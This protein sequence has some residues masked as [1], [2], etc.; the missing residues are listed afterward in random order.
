MSYTRCFSSKWTGGNPRLTHTVLVY[1]VLLFMVVGGNL[2]YERGLVQRRFSVVQVML[3]LVWILAT[4]LFEV[5]EDLSPVIQE[6]SWKR[7]RGILVMVWWWVWTT[8]SFWG[9]IA[10]QHCKWLATGVSYSSVQLRFFPV[11]QKWLL[12]LLTF[13]LWPNLNSSD[14]VY[15]SGIPAVN[16]EL[17]KCLRSKMKHPKLKQLYHSVIQSFNGDIDYK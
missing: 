5:L 14:T 16:L 8:E 15:N 3:I 2:H 9:W 13:L 7:S 4:G 1:W 12:L 17:K 11:Q 10:R 6:A